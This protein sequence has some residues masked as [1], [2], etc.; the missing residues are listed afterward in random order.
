MADGDE[1]LWLRN[2]VAELEAIHELIAD[3]ILFCHR[4]SGFLTHD[5]DKSPLAYSIF[6]SDTFHMACADAESITPEEA[7][8]LHKIMRGRP[9][10]I[11]QWHIATCWVAWKRGLTRKDI[12]YREAMPSVEAFEYFTGAIK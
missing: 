5:D 2:K 6:C 4:D 11:S 1:V 9:E 10:G 7:V 12:V 3:D 8:T